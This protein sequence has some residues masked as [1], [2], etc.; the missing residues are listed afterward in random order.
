MTQLTDEPVLLV[1]AL[2]LLTIVTVLAALAAAS[3]G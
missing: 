1:E 2:A 3:K